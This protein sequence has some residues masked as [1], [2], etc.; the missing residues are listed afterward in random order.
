MKRRMCTALALTLS[1]LLTCLGTAAAG[2]PKVGSWIEYLDG[3]MTRF[4]NDPQNAKSGHDGFCYWGQDHRSSHACTV[5]TSTDRRPLV[6]EHPPCPST[7][8]P[9]ICYKVRLAGADPK[10]P[11][12]Y[13]RWELSADP[14]SKG[15]LPYCQPE[16]VRWN[17][18]YHSTP[19]TGVNKYRCGFWR[20]LYTGP[21]P[22]TPSEGG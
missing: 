3:R 11:G 1:A 9:R 13:I 12:W 7:D 6:L 2:V 21:G 5:D 8:N 18:G 15:Q 20:F 22:L 14:W 4:Y 19:W 10:H 17:L 16:W